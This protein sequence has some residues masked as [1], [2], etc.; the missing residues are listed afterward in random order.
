MNKK[1]LKETYHLSIL[2]KSLSRV[3]PPFLPPKPDKLMKRSGGH[4]ELSCSNVKKSRIYF[5]GYRS[6]PRL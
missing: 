1:H 2:T 5:P 6:I 4:Q 3:V